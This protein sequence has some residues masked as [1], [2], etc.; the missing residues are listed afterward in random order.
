MSD[1]PFESLGGAGGGFDLQGLLQHVFRLLE[2][3]GPAVH[4]AF[5]L[6]AERRLA[7]RTVADA[8]GR[9]PNRRGGR[10]AQSILR[11]AA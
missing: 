5:E 2:T 3:L 9:L 8:V 1:N 10:P 6:R 7:I 11:R 4:A